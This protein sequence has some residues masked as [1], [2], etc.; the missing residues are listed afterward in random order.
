MLRLRCKAICRVPSLHNIRLSVMRSK[1]FVPGS[2]PELFAKAVASGAD[3]LS[4]DLEDSVSMDRKEEA[5]RAVS[6]FL[7][8]R[9]LNQCQTVLVR[10]NG[11]ASGLLEADV[12]ALAGCGIDVINVP[13][14]ESA[15]DVRQALD[16]IPGD[17]KIL[18]NIETP[19]GLRLAAEIATA[20]ARIAGLQLGFI[21]LFSQCGID[22]RETAAKYSIRL[23]VRLAAAEAGI[24][25]F[26]SAFAEVKNL[27]GFRAE[28]EA[29][30]S[31]GFS[32]KSCIH[33][34]Q[35]A[36]ANQ[37]FAPSRH[38][39]ARAEEI[40]VAMRER[41]QDVFLLDG[42][43]IDKPILERARDVVRLAESLKARAE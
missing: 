30:R 17:I 13:K 21:D 39:I 7:H 31:L 34:T 8:E 41:G 5:R 3:A 32:G 42:Q 40:L 23:A 28:A 43:M 2:R 35:V 1:L 15:D 25:V 33:P 36:I 10:V 37:V 9:A 22:S 26:D 38:E 19:K 6:E 24:A 4:F 14:V 29:A 20:D 18:A 12:K 27:E 16:V 11:L